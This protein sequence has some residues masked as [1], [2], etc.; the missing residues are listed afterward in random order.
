M[1]QLTTDGHTYSLRVDLESYDGEKIFAVYDNFWIGPESDQYRLHVSGFSA[2]ST[3][4]KIQYD[5]I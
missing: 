3:A 4:G 5:V 1:H 2:Q